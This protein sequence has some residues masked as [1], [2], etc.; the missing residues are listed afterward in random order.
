MR[1]IL[2]IFMIFSFISLSAKDGGSVYSRYGL[3]DIR[4]FPSGRSAGFGGVSAAVFSNY[5]INRLNPAAWTTLTRTRYEVSGMY[6]GIFTSDRVKSAYFADMTFTGFMISFPIMPSRGITL[7]GGIVPFSSVK[8]EVTTPTIGEQLQYEN[9]YIGEGGISVGHIGSSVRIGSDINIGAKLNYYFGPLSYTTKQTFSGSSYTNAEVRRSTYLKGIGFTFGGIFTGL[10]HLL[11]FPKSSSLNIGLMITT[12]SDLKQT[13][14]KYY[15][16]NTQVVLSYDTLITEKEDLHFPYAIGGGISYTTERLLIAS[17]FH[18]QKWSGRSVFDTP[19]LQNAM[20]IALGTEL[21]P[22]KDPSQ[23]PLKHTVYR[24]GIYYN[25]TYY[26]IKNRSI[27]EFGITAG[28][29]IPVFGEIRLDMGIGFSMR[30]TTEDYL[31]KENIIRLTFSL[32]GGEPW[33]VRPEQD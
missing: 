12:G 25:S 4:Y 29:G 24:A 11:N 1:R 19:E 14:E 18:F 22:K 21:L 5:S 33:F 13:E 16:Y 27:D 30:G 7:A 10:N 31:Q 26:K 23:S 9:R 15:K 20:R 17:D 32:A 28:M 3:G 8:Y 6:E 2:Y